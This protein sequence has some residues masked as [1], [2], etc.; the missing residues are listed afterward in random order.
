MALTAALLP[1]GRRITDF[2]SLG[3]IARTF[4]PSKA[5]RVLATCGKASLRERDLPAHVVV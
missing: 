3:V 4:P 1:K 5:H 2:I